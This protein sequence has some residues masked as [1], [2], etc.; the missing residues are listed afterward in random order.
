MAA[1]PQQA[2]TLALIYQADALH[3]HLRQALGELGARIV[4]ETHARDYD[5]AALD[6]SGASVIVINLDPAGGDEF[7]ALYELLLDETRRVIFN[8]GE[9]TSR[10][11]GWDLARWTRHLAAKV[12]GATEVHPPRPQGA[13]AIPVKVKSVPHARGEAANEAASGGDF[14]L[15]GAEFAR[16]MSA[17]TG[18]AIERERA[19]LR[20]D[21]V[22]V[23]PDLIPRPGSDA[24][25]AV[26][27]AELTMHLP[28]DSAPVEARGAAPSEPPTLELPIEDIGPAATRREFPTLELAA[29]D[30]TR[31]AAKLGSETT[32]ADAGTAAEVVAA[33]DAATASDL[34]FDHAPPADALASDD[35]IEDRNAS[36]TLEL[37]AVALGLRAPAPPAAADD[38]LDFGLDPSAL[39]FDLEP[40]EEGSFAPAAA[41]AVAAT[42]DSIDLSFD[43]SLLAAIDAPLQQAMDARTA[44]TD[45][46]TSESGLDGELLEMPEPPP[47]GF[48]RLPTA[49]EEIASDD[50]AEALRD[51][52]FLDEEPEA[53]RGEAVMDLD[54]L[55]MRAGEAEEEKRKGSLG[56][57][58]AVF[59]SAG[60]TPTPAAAA[61]PAAPPVAARP[62]PPPA[63]A[64]ESPK[65][66][67]LADFEA[68]L[69]GLSLEPADDAPSGEPVAPPR[70]A[71]PA[72]T[73]APAPNFESSLGGLTLEPIEGESAPK[74]AS[75]RAVF[76]A[77]EP[78]PA[79]P[80]KPAAPAPAPLA[81]KAAASGDE[82]SLEGY[83]FDFGENTEIRTDSIV[84]IGSEPA[85]DDMSVDLD[86]EIDALLQREA[87]LADEGLPTVSDAPASKIAR[88]YVLGASIGGPDAV[89]EF[90]GALPPDVPALFLLA[91]HM[92]ADFLELM[93][94]QL[95]RASKLKVRTVEDG[96]V[97]SHG[98]VVIVPLAG[99]L[100]VDPDGRATVGPLPAP[101]PYSP[102]IDQV[103][104]DAADRF[105]AKTGAIIFSGMAHDA[106][107][108]AR[109][110]VSKG[111]SVWVQDPSSCVISSMVDGAR[112]AGI[113]SH[114]ARPS[115]LARH[116][117]EQCAK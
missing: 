62:A 85:F 58:D 86:S 40:L 75:G 78:E 46:P 39:D 96:D 50:F 17:D 99:R 51:F 6:A 3:Q 114:T 42:D 91:Q 52:G 95:S 64:P 59:R 16:A 70:G 94:Q 115:E 63:R 90:L 65:E 82:L 72:P 15:G 30:L 83:D 20:T 43:E 100:E 5:Q 112:E 108:G 101:S 54:T 110:I 88:V 23:R 117:V 36:P 12:M 28:A 31:A 27:P 47:G 104:R 77:V 61:A 33:T 109:Y 22:A 103:M 60:I 26:D 105:G 2:L 48:A 49:A 8:D 97:L 44:S 55:L 32:A 41:E 37:D 80:A 19:A 10:L 68:A 87:S 7:D 66:R 71:T 89:R 34:A 29:E 53:P 4:Y 1:M 74:P 9:V 67:T 84:R 116:L 45:S 35:F 56:N 81:A 18:V 79:K 111:G 24:T 25:Y 113:V 102:S 21:H 106:I 76:G 14:D 73:A 13:E 107:E 69:A 98:E 38:G 92:G 93:V 57:V 11:E